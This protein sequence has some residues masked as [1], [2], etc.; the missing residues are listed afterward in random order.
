MPDAGG[1]A[2]RGTRLWHIRHGPYDCFM[3][4]KKTVFGQS[5]KLES[6]RRTVGEEGMAFLE[7]ALRGFTRLLP[8]TQATN[9]TVKNSNEWTRVKWADSDRRALILAVS[10]TTSNDSARPISTLISTLTRKTAPGGVGQIERTLDTR[11]RDLCLQLSN[12]I[13]AVLSA[14]KDGQNAESLRAIRSLFDEQVVAGHLQA[15]HGITLDVGRLFGVLRGLA[16]QSYENKALTFGIIIRKTEKADNN[17]AVFPFDFL[18][19]KRYRAL[20]D[21]FRT[22][23]AVSADGRL[24]GLADLKASTAK[25]HQKSFYPEWCEY[26]AEAS[27]DGSCG[28]CL[29]RQGDLLV[30]DSGGLRF[31]YRCGRWQY[32]NHTHVTDILRNRARV[33]RVPK[34]VLPEVV[35]DIYRAALDVSFRRSGGLFVLLRSRENKKKLLIKGDAIGDSNREVLHKEFD[36]TLP[37]ATV[38]TIPRVILSELAGLDG[39]VVVD[40]QGHILAYGAVLKAS[41]RFNPSEGSRTKAAISASRYGIAVKVSSDGDITFYEQRRAFM[42]M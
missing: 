20:S 16:E 14:Q 27:R 5:K 28:I 10:I 3:N 18:E 25:S 24:L 1:P 34:N 26:I 22:A 19:K 13:G 39:A 40:N 38:Q 36:G 7:H 35:R 15:Y 37:D 32:W 11:E 41:G 42:E 33:Q 30:F 29:T 31:T 23:Y 2:A 17:G 12:R 9:W 4:G 21:G 8:H 6:L